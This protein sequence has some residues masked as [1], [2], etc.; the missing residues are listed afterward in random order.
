MLEEYRDLEWRWSY[1][2]ASQ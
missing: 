2:M 1:P